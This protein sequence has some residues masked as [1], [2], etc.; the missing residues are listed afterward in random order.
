MLVIQGL[1]CVTARCRRFVLDTEMQKHG[2][3]EVL[4]KKTSKGKR[5]D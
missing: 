2:L 1:K 4:D 3:Q 5:R